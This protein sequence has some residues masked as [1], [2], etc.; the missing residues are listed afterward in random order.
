MHLQITA[1]SN[2]DTI[3]NSWIVICE[4][5]SP[6]TLFVKGGPDGSVVV[7]ATDPRVL[8]VAGVRASGRL[9][10]G[11]SRGPAYEYQKRLHRRRTVP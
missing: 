3:L 10:E 8:S 1:K 5:D 2:T 6:L 11:S 9:W 4:K 7:P